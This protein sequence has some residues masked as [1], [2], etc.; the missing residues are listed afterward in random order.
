MHCD[1]SRVESKAPLGEDALSFPAQQALIHT[2]SICPSQRQTPAILQGKDGLVTRAALGLRRI[3]AFSQ[4]S[5]VILG[6]H[7]IWL[8]LRPPAINGN[9][10]AFVLSLW[11]VI[12]R[13]RDCLLIGVSMYSTYLIG[14]LISGG[15]S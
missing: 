4:P 10:V 15:P 6:K 5:C 13:G 7:F 9:S 14:P 2:S 8:S 3:K 1:A 12:S 11:T